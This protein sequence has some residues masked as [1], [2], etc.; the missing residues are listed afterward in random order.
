M[1]LVFRAY[2]WA[3][4]VCFDDIQSERCM[5]ELSSSKLSAE[6]KKPRK[7]NNNYNVMCALSSNWKG[8]NGMTVV[9]R[10][11]SIWFGWSNW[12]IEILTSQFYCLIMPYWP[13]FSLNRFSWRTQIWSS[14]VPFLSL[15]LSICECMIFRIHRSA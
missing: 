2:T 15:S 13:L 5:M 6:S 8:L 10:S 11:I 4:F 12:E 14:S 7:N 3:R 9:D 1:F